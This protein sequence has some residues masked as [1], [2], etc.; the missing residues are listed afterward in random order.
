[1][2]L[3]LFFKQ[4]I[5]PGFIFQSVIMAGGYGTGKEIVTFFLSLGPVSGLMAMGVASLIW[6]LMCGLTFE[7][8][9]CHHAYD[10]YTFFKAL[11]GKGWVFFELAYLGVVTIVLAIIAASSGHIVSM[12]LG[13]SYNVG[14]IG[15]MLYVSFMLLKGSRTIAFALSIWS[16]LLYLVY[17][18][19]FAQCYLQE[20]ETIWQNLS[21]LPNES[22]WFLAGVEYAGY[23]LGL[24]PGVFFILHYQKTTKQTIGSGFLAGILAMLPGMMFFIAML[25]MYPQVLTQEV[26]STFILQQLN[27]PW[28]L[29]GFHIVLFGTLI[30]TATGLIH[31]LNQRINVF[32]SQQGRQ[33]PS[34]LRSV[35]G[36]GCL[37]VASGLAQFGLTPLVA[38][39]Y[40]T[41][42]WVIIA[43]FVIPMISIGVMKI[44]SSSKRVVMT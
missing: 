7:F 20:G 26:P 34:S 36:I 23:N 4:W 32:F 28:F 14:V 21:Q 25:S 12:T 15:F 13:W 43:V 41:L 9:R 19:F 33:M 29:I 30:E 27:R 22:G 42:T 44:M 16:V 18:V 10:Y 5:L 35:V 11:L 24:I 2:Q 3:G 6:G 17:A 1:M 39:G 38:K 8:A 37:L 40:G 31:A